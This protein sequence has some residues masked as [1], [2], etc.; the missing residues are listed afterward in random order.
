MRNL[1][2]KGVKRK[3][4]NVIFIGHVLLTFDEL[5]PKK[6]HSERTSYKQ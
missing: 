6:T 5:T 3:T 1:V 2:K 4:A